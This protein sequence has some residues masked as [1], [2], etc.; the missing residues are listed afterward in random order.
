MSEEN[1]QIAKRF[2]EALGSNDAEGVAAH[3]A[4]D[5]I[6]VTKGYSQFSGTRDAASIVGTLASFSGVLPKGLQLTVRSVFGEDDRMVVEAEGNT[7]TAQGDSYHNQY[8]FVL[9][10]RDGKVV[11]FN[12]YFCTLHAE[13]ILWPAVVQWSAQT[14]SS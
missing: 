11:H 4:S 8:C 7:I 14:A 1:K 10:M 6:A 9:T 5:G 2:I 13:Q 3:F 12:E